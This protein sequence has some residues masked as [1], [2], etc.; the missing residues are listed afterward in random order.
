VNEPVTS[1]LAPARWSCHHLKI[2]KLRCAHFMQQIRVPIQDLKQLHQCERRLSF[3][4]LIALESISAA[5]EDFS[6]FD[7]SFL[8]ETIKTIQQ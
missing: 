4:V 3:A 8:K 6:G 2:A 7:Y 5:A 1:G